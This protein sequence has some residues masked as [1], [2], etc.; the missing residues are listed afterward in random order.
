MICP[1]VT[2]GSQCG[3]RSGRGTIDTIF[4]VR[5]IMEKCVEQQVPLFQVF[6]DV[7]KTFHSINRS[8]RWT[9][10]LKLGCHP[11]FV[12]IVRQLH[13]NMCARVC[14]SGKLSAPLPVEN[15]VK[16]G[17]ILPPT[18]FSIYFTVMFEFAFRE[19][20]V[21]AFIRFRTSGKLFNLRCLNCKSKTLIREFLYAD[22]AVLVA[23]TREDM[24]FIM[25]VFSK[26]CTAF[27]LTISIKK[28]KVMYAPCP[29]E[30]FVEPVILCDGIQLG[31]VDNFIYL[32]SKLSRDS[33]LDA[34]INNRI[35][36]ASVACGK[37]EKRVWSD[38]GITVNTKLGVYSACVLSCLLYGSETST[39]GVT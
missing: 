33:S 29:G 32:R 37:L 27:G 30:A 36:K 31:G 34:E 4:S 20:A 6:L 28:T 18:L 38:H 35:P 5:Q 7:T 13:R 24:Q 22:D 15:G 25:D 2:P 21:G 8:A 17:D 16:Q 11:E 10:L 19:C 14:V 3:F 12:D 39:T 9:V 26:A 1:S 23:H